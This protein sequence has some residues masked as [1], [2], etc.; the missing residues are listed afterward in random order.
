MDVRTHVEITYSRLCA[1]RDFQRGCDNG[2]FDLQLEFETLLAAVAA[3]AA[4]AHCDV[5]RFAFQRV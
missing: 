4:T 2:K 3:A 5:T 1:G